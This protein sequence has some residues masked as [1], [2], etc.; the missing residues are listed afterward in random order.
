MTFSTPPRSSS[1]LVSKRRFNS[2]VIDLTDSPVLK[3]FKADD[4]D[5]D[6]IFIEPIVAEPI[7]AEPIVAEP[8]VAEPIV[9]EPIVAIPIVDDKI[10][11]IMASI[12]GKE[13]VAFRNSVRL[14][15]STTTT[16]STTNTTDDDS[17]DYLCDD[18][19]DDETFSSIIADLRQLNDAHA[20][21]DNGAS[22]LFTYFD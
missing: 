19:I 4:D 14:S 18:D 1:R 7:V 3:L 10:V 5:D 20:D 22:M 11:R 12:L 6:V 21:F 15:E 8:I 17:L 13:M 2:D 16:T 9:A